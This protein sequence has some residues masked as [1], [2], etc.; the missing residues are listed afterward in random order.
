[1]HPIVKR[2]ASKHK[3]R[4][5]G[6]VLEVGSRYINGTIR[7]VLPITI[8]IDFLDGQC[9]DRVLDVQELEATYGPDS[10]DAVVSA[11]ALEHIEDWRGALNNMWNVLKM[12]G[13]LFCTLA[14]IKKGRH[15][16]PDDYHRWHL[17]DFKKLF[18]DNPILGEMNETISIGV[19]VQ[20]K[21]PLTLT[22]EPYKVP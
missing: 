20:K 16:Y 12:D 18:G 1:M 15:A 14:S 3:S 10:F 22:I 5:T 4:F 19:V 8:G 6:N 13:H 17:E 9:V 2:F 21:G 7:D 11:D